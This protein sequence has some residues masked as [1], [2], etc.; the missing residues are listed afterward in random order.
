LPHQFR[1]DDGYEPF[2]FIHFNCRAI[3][4]NDVLSKYGE[5]RTDNKK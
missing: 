2:R 4:I 3:P 5:K 1:V